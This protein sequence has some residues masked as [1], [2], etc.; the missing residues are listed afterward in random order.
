VRVSGRDP[1]TT[2]GEV[3]ARFPAPLIVVGM[4]GAEVLSESVSRALAAT[5]PAPVLI[6]PPGAHL[7]PFSPCADGEA[8]HSCLAARGPQG[9]TRPRRIA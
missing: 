1:A 3:A 8:G 9:S 2:L 5:A 6:V 4:R 7:P